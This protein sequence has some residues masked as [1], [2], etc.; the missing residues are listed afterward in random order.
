MLIQPWAKAGTHNSREIYKPKK[1]ACLF[2]PNVFIFANCVA[3]N[4]G[5]VL[6]TECSCFDVFD[7]SLA[8]SLSHS[9]RPWRHRCSCIITVCVFLMCLCVPLVEVN[10]Q[11]C[12]CRKHSPELETSKKIPKKHNFAFL[13]NGEE[14]GEQRQRGVLRRLLR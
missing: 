7:V 8:L 13:T 5:R 12:T 9:H 10:A 4:S 2:L 1:T 11:S 3:P 14:R 6:S